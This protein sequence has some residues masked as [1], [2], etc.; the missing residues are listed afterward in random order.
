MCACVDRRIMAAAS[1]SLLLLVAGYPNSTAAAGALSPATL[2]NSPSAPR[3]PVESGSE[4]MG[5]LSVHLENPRY[6]ADARGNAVYLT[7]SHTWNT[8]Q[9]MLVA[10]GYTL[11]FDV[12][13]DF[14]ERHGH[15]F[16]RLWIWE[17]ASRAPWS[18][19]ETRFLPLPYERPGPGAALDG[20]PRFDLESFN[21]AFFERL[22]SRVAKAQEH[23]VYVSVMLFQGFSLDQKG[24]ELETSTWASIR[25]RLSKLGLGHPYMEVN[26]PWIDHPFNKENNINGLDGDP[27]SHGD[28]RDVHTLRIPEVTRIQ[29][30]FVRKMID[31]LNEFENVL[32]EI[33]NESH[34]ESAAWQYHMIDFIHEY[35]KSKTQQH[36][37][38][39]TVP[40]PEGDN[41]ILF[42]SP[43]EAISPN[44]KNGHRDNTAVADGTKVMIVDT[45]HLWGI[46]GDWRWVWKSFLSGMNPIF[47][48]PYHAPGFQEHPTRGEWHAIRRSMGDTRK[49]ADRIDLA[50][51]L[52]KPEL[53]SSG[54]CLADPGKRYLVYVTGG[55]E[56][57]VDSSAAPGKLQIEWFDPV[58]GTSL[59][60]GTT[61]GT[62]AGAFRSPVGNDAILHL[63]CKEPCEP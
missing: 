9:D 49:L 60:S 20:Q 54:F 3:M 35:E 36:P 22:R 12:Y 21:Q 29:E 37:V 28:G 8:V 58:T 39:M 32:W 5:P 48:D 16:L 17:Q 14:L 33:A 55:D 42:A 38:I 13:L 41:A 34:A 57:I 27:L 63:R 44:E 10:D 15:N 56:T 1:F 26:N 40:W 2:T 62:K 31:T 18:R 61:R 19:D 6:F 4:S 46:G 45:D 47:M 25:R 30:A 43:A 53:A 59:E 24:H 50:R 7:G 11:D 23:G 52:P 51:M